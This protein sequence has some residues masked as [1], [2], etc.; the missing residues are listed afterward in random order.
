MKRITFVLSLFIACF[1]MQAQNLTGVESVEYDPVSG[2]FFVTNGNSIVIINGDEES[3]GYFGSGGASY[4][5]EVMNDVLW[6]IHNNQVKGYNLGDGSLLTTVP[7][8][9]ASFLNGMASDGESRLWVTDFSLKKIHQIDV[10]DID[11]PSVS[12]LVANTTTTPNGIVHDAGANR[13]LFVNWGANAAV[14]AVDLSDNSVS[15]VTNTTLGNCDGID[16][17]NDGN[18]YISSWSPTRITKFSA[19]FTVSETI[20]V[21]GLSS[22]AD[23]CYAR[24]IDTLAI[25]NSGTNT[26]RLVGFEQTSGIAEEKTEVGLHIYP[27]PVADYFTLEFALDGTQEVQVDI[28]DMKGRRVKNVIRASFPAGRQKIVADRTD[29]SKGNYL[30][31]V[32]TKKWIEAI[33]F[34]IT[35]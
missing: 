33:P 17:D 6:A 28:F 27:N 1:G 23:I 26:V 9:G 29:L 24:E 3:D 20:T 14:K 12:V 16:N 2:R 13:L 35:E 25:P 30:C 32:R 34:V 18:Y 11:N 4:G 10:S 5:M 22:P 31:K 19:D 21:T 8:S 15:I 7:V